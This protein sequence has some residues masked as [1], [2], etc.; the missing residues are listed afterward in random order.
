MV[1]STER[2]SCQESGECTP[3]LPGQDGP[4]QL[5]RHLRWG[6]VIMAVVRWFSTLLSSYPNLYIY[7]L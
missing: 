4:P 3:E 2:E 7:H 5:L 6:L 1:D